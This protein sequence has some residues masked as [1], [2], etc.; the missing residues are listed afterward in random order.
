[1]D[2]LANA[3]LTHMKDDDAALILNLLRGNSAAATTPE[4]DGWL[5]LHLAVKSQVYE[6]GSP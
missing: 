6:N 1:M 5:P 2:V 3:S 4:K